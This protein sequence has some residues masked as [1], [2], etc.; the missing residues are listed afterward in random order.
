MF[1]D[2]SDADGLESFKLIFDGRVSVLLSARGRDVACWRSTMLISSL[3]VLGEF[4]LKLV[5]CWICTT[6]LGL[7][8]QKR[9]LYEK[10]MRNF[11]KSQK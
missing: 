3:G 4:I 11:N 8:N 1:Q 7:I 10:E 6:V 9:G 2:A 5:I